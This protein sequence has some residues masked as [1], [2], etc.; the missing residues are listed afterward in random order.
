MKGMKGNRGDKVNYCRTMGRNHR[1][2]VKGIVRSWRGV[3]WRD[4]APCGARHGEAR[5]GGAKEGNCGREGTAAVCMRHVWS[6]LAA[7]KCV[8]SSRFSPFPRPTCLLSLHIRKPSTCRN[9]LLRLGQ[10]CLALSAASAFLK[11]WSDDA[12]VV[13]VSDLNS[14]SPAMHC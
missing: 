14:H 2:A 4:V 11:Q 13:V 10:G 5:R 7:A 1:K 8:L 12:A 6:C 9:S 3:A